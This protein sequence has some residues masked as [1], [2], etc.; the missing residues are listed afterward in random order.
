MTF[1]HGHLALTHKRAF[2]ISCSMKSLIKIT[3]ALFLTIGMM[4]IFH[5]QGVAYN[6]VGAATKKPVPKK[7]VL[8]PEIRFPAP[9][10]EADQ[11]YLGISGKETFTISDVDADVLL[12]EVMN[13]NCGSCQQ[14][15]PINNHLFSLMQSTPEAAGRIKMMA[16]SAGTRYK[17][18]QD[19][20]NYFKT[21][22][23]VIEDPEFVL[24]DAVGRTPTPFAIALIK[25]ADG[26][27]S[28][29]AETHKGTKSNYKKTLKELQALLDETSSAVQK[30]GADLEDA[31][32]QVA[33]V[34][35]EQ[36]L[37]QRIKAA[38]ETEGAFS[39]FKAHQLQAIG[40]IY[41][42]SVQG[43]NGEKRLFAMPVSSPVPCDV[44]HDVH[45]FYVFDSAGK[46]LSLVPIQLTKYGN[47][48]LSENDVQFLKERIVGRYLFNTF[49]YDLKVDAVSAAT[50]TT[51]V[52]YRNIRDGRDVY[53]ALVKEGLIKK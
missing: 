19:F 37:I 27:L 31:W 5:H 29:V 11:K 18:I 28:L 47:D 14:Q 21:P 24:Y 23:P 13:I 35:S 42:A 7:G 16:I 2:A 51:S 17:D 26:K 34:L 22:Y 30:A 15:A 12:V 40:T 49:D 25:N 50:I 10:S 33:P 20:R 39:D 32:V 45:F 53:E 9:P 41:T 3:F 48:P 1:C 43:N 4:G 36:E 6:K 44:C 46:I 52:V 8:F 38:F